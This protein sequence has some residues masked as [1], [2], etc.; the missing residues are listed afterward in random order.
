MTRGGVVAVACAWLGCGATVQSD[1]AARRARQRAPER[2]T[3]SAASAARCTLAADA[4]AASV[5]CTVP[6]DE[7]ARAYLF[8]REPGQPFARTA[9]QAAGPSRY[10]ARLPAA[11]SPAAEY[12]VAVY[13]G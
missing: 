2:T 7:G 10:S 9:L 1:I 11:P 12:Y 13:R 8:V 6:G 5:A 4:G 3:P